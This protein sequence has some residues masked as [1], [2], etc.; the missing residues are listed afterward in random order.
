[1]KDPVVHFG[2]LQFRLDFQS[3]VITGPSTLTLSVGKT[4]NGV[5]TLA[6]TEV[7]EATQCLDDVFTVT[8]APNL[9]YIC[10]TNS[11]E[12]GTTF[13]KSTWVWTPNF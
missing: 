6:G 5:L 8:N 13:A 7:A 3:F 9:P 2:I 12:H 1:M 11:G 10:G 4:T